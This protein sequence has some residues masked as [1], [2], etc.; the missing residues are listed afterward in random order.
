MGKGVFRLL[1]HAGIVR[2]RWLM[3]SDSRDVAAPMKKL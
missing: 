3:V 2:Y 1:G